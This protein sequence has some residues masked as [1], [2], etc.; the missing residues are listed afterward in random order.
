MPFETLSQARGREVALHT[1]RRTQYYGILHEFDDNGNFR[2]SNAVEYEDGV[3]S[4]MGEIV[5]NGINV[6]LVDIRK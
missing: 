4:K 2:I 1:R 3:L 5:I 6:V